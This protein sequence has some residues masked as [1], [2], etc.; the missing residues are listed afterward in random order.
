M[1][2]VGFE[3]VQLNGLCRLKGEE[4]SLATRVFIG[5]SVVCL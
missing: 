1:T 5:K 4:C 3:K 2:H